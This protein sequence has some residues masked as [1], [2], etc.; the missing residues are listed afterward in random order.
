MDLQRLVFARAPHGFKTE[1]RSSELRNSELLLASEVFPI[2]PTTVSAQKQHR[3]LDLSTKQSL[4]A[5]R[6]TLWVDR[7]SRRP[8]PGRWFERNEC[9]SYD[10]LQHSIHP[11]PFVHPNNHIA[12]SASPSVL[13]R[14]RPTIRSPPP[15]SLSVAVRLTP[16]APATW[17]PPLQPACSP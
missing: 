9:D 7:S 2:P 10:P 4:E 8:S 16:P 17:R 11:T 1:T 3:E 5:W 15:P 6:A 14:H 12:F 13:L